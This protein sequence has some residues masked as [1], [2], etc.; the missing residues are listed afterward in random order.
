MTE[1]ID[2]NLVSPG[3]WNGI[4]ENA[5]R[6]YSSD[7]TSKA[8]SVLSALHNRHIGITPG[9]AI[10]L[11]GLLL[12]PGA[13]RNAGN[14][15][16]DVI[17][18][19]EEELSDTGYSIGVLLGSMASYSLLR[20][21]GPVIEVACRRIQQCFLFC[22]EEVNSG[23]TL[24]D[25]TRYSGLIETEVKKMTQERD[26]FFKLFWVDRAMTLS[27]Y[28]R[29]VFQW[30]NVPRGIPGTQ[31]MSLGMMLRLKAEATNPRY[32]APHPKPLT[33]PLK[34]RETSRTNEGGFSGIF[35]TRRQ[36]DIGDI[37][38]SEFI[39]PPVVLSERLTGSGFMALR[40]QPKR[41]NLRDMLLVGI[42]PGEIG[43][44]PSADFIKGCWMDLL[45]RLGMVLVQTGRMRSEFRWIEGD[46]FGGE[47]SCQ[48]LLQDL[49]EAFVH[50]KD[51]H[52][53]GPGLRKRFL[54]AT[55]W[56][57]QFID[58]GTCF[59]IPE[60]VKGGGGI[61][62]NVSDS[63]MKWVFSTW[64]KQKENALWLNKESEMQS[65]N[66]VKAKSIDTK[67]Y[68]VIHIMVF[69]PASM[70]NAETVSS[71][72][73]LSAI[74]K[75]LGLGNTQGVSAGITWVP[76]KLNAL[77]QW[78]IDFRGIKE[79]VLFPSSFKQLKGNIHHIA[80]RIVETWQDY[81][82]KELQHG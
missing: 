47:K 68:S 82:I 21:A 77:D 53:P 48:F 11:S 9:L 79:T 65:A 27:A 62:R 22:Q 58:T 56:M 54:M 32:V 51:F 14:P 74:Y 23:I 25:Y 24:E 35:I 55:G 78:G 69:L 4:L 13:S 41:E 39:N 38:L 12:E 75:G 20:L 80:G 8:Y 26:E 66:V 1:Q 5:F 45:S 43:P 76:Q 30:E 71:A 73:R 63:S 59:D 6:G 36:E 46:R 37:L 2:I 50:S 15:W 7:V 17:K 10:G 72:A 42:M 34:H 49:P 33:Q 40:R 61:R 52:V 19:L 60:G 67:R 70:R 3:V 44:K 64:K 31:P 28:S 18:R 29:G 57:P 81:L 16:N